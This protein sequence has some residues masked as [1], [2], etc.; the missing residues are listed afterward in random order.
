[1]THRTGFAFWWRF[2][3]LVG[4]VSFGASLLG[5]FLERFVLQQWLGL[6]GFAVLPTGLTIAAILSLRHWFTRVAGGKPCEDAGVK[7]LTART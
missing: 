3:A 1:M 7:G 5:T 2:V 4:G 6:Q